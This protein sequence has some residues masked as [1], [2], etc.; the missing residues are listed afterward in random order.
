MT[1]AM[2][3]PCGGVDAG[4]EEVTDE[5]TRPKRA[6]KRADPEQSDFWIVTEYK[7]F[8]H[9]TLEGA[10]A[11]RGRLHQCFPD[12]QFRVHRCKR[13]LP[14]RVGRVTAIPD[15]GPPDFSEVEEGIF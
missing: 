5:A 9:A 14:G 7:F 8:Q 3:R 1:E 10:E 11:E 13:H 15:L 2:R 12:K 4:E 6:L